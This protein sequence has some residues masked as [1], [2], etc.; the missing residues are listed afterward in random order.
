MEVKE[1]QATYKILEYH[2]SKLPTNYTALVYSRW[3]RSLRFG[4]PLFRKITSHQYYKHYH[5][6]I[7]KLLAKP[8][9]LTRLAV[10]EEDHD[11]C[12]GFSVSR[13][14]VLDYVHV[15]TDNRHIGIGTSLVPKGISTFTHITAIAIEIWNSREEYRHLKFNPFA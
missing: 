4:N 15:H 14:D 10:L 1:P 3:L 5:I 7:E 12:L 2:S 11:V 9:S 13:E 6:Y 8:D